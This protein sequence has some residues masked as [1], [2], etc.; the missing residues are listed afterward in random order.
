[1]LFHFP[2]GDFPASIIEFICKQH[3]FILKTVQ[4]QLWLHGYEKKVRNNWNI[5]F[6]F[7][8]YPYI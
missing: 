8:I 4:N 5:K 7:I 1:M 6:I 2:H 3:L